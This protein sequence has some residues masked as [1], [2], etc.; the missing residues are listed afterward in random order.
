MY[1]ASLPEFRIKIV[2]TCPHAD[3]R[4]GI[5]IEGFGFLLCKYVVNVDSRDVSIIARRHVP[6]PELTR[7]RLYG[8]AGTIMVALHTKPKVSGTE[9]PKNESSTRRRFIAPTYQNYCVAP[10]VECPLVLHNFDRCEETETV[11]K[12]YKVSFYCFSS[13]NVCVRRD[14][15]CGQRRGL[16]GRRR[17]RRWR[18][19]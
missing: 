6:G 1:C 8:Y 3:F 11:R 2:M 14:H 17:W 18:R 7:K 16:R 15:V 13:G 5:V 4:C 9:K 12:A 19:W 10:A